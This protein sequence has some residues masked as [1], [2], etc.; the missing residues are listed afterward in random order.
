MNQPCQLILQNSP[1]SASASGPSVCLS[2]YTR[3]EGEWGWVW[4]GKKVFFWGGNLCRV[5][6]G[7][8]GPLWG[9]G[10][11]IK[12]STAASA[13]FAC[14]IICHMLHSTAIFHIRAWKLQQ[15]SLRVDQS[16]HLGGQPPWSSAE[17]MIYSF[18][19]TLFTH[20]IPHCNAHFIIIES[21][22][23]NL[24]NKTHLS[25]Q[26]FR[27]NIYISIK[28]SQVMLLRMTTMSRQQYKKKGSAILCHFI[29]F[30][31]THLTLFWSFICDIHGSDCTFPRMLTISDPFANF[32]LVQIDGKNSK[33][34]KCHCPVV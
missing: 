33:C 32:N 1:P 8:E 25:A 4:R 23:I 13:W 14:L 34:T 26:L 12:D 29:F 28:Y 27:A 11:I 16:V 17:V 2:G 30:K 10:T 7:G 5:E 3:A 22:S 20:K 9:T 18:P 31:K 24:H 6:R 15:T 21:N 19:I